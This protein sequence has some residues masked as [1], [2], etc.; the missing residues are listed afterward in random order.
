MRILILPTWYVSPERPD[1]GIYFREQALALIKAGQ[2]TGVIYVDIGLGNAW[3]KVRK[4][5]LFDRSLSIDEGMPTLRIA[6]IGLPKRFAWSQQLY[7]KLVNKCYEEY[8]Q[9]FGAPDIIHAHGYTAGF[10]ASR[11]KQQWKVPFVYSEHMSTL[12]DHQYPAAHTSMLQ[13]SLQQAGCCH[14]GKFCFI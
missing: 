8:C 13:A 9:K 4:M 5:R 10:A 6:A 14:C 3:N 7:A 2:E 12:K 1:L 11:I